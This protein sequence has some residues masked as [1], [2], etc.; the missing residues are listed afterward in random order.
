MDSSF[1][2]RSVV[3][4][5]QVRLNHAA[6]NALMARLEAQKAIC[7]ASEKELHSIHKQK[8]EI[9]KQIQPDWEKAR[10]R[11]RVNDDFLINDDKED[12]KPVLY[13][14]GIK[15]RSP[16]HKELRV[17]LEEEQR[18]ALTRFSPV[19]E[20]KH[21]EDRYNEEHGVN[22]VKEIEEAPD[23]ETGEINGR[24]REGFFSVVKEQEREEDGETR[25]LR[26]KENVDKWL[27]M[28]LENTP[29]EPASPE[30]KDQTKPTSTNDIDIIEDL[31]LKYPHDAEKCKEEVL[32]KECE[33][34]KKG[35]VE[36]ESPKPVVTEAGSGRKVDRKEKREK[37]G[38]EKV[39]ARS[40]S[41]R[42]F[43]R[44]PSSPSIILGMKKGVD[45][46][47]K[48]SM[49]FSDDEGDENYGSRRNILSSSFKSI[50]K[51]VKI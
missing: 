39:L 12:H 50:K 35:T 14:P 2:C 19:S 40:E 11:S 1:Y 28:L 31:N 29:D 45:C 3:Y 22:A 24:C 25:K 18:A 16:L 49:V 8:D 47:R 30:G 43:R 5:E 44:I 34:K 27:Q 7:N 6:A 17:L 15:P 51:A 4:K 48:K 42:T 38:K 13:L 9:E 21:E 20:L 37:G 41:A 32:E 33:D 26:G 23:Y 10:K 46:I 36:T